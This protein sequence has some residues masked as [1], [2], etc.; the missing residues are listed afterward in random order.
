MRSENDNW[1]VKTNN[2]NEFST[3][4]IIIAGGVGS[5]EPRKLAV[6]N[7]EKFEGKSVFYAIK[8]KEDFKNKNICIFGGGDSALDW[9]LELSK[10]S[11]ITLIHRRDEFRGAQHTLD[12]IKKLEKQGKISIKTPFQL[13]KVEGDNEVTSITIKDDNGK[14]ENIKTDVI[15]S[16]FGLVMKLRSN[17]RVGFKHE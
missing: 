13:E 11:N 5:F 1:F 6:K 4:N 2:G 7:L 9:T 16:F 8:N 14:T 3:P 12:A 10:F 15:L 17:S